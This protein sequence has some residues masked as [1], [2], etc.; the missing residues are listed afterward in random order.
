[1][2]YIIFYIFVLHDMQDKLKTKLAADTLVLITKTNAAISQMRI[3]LLG[4]A[5]KF[6]DGREPETNIFFI[7]ALQIC[8]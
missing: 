5:Y 7:L 6:R 4:L 1:M 8:R 2:Q 3:E